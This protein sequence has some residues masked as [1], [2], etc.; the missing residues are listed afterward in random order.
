MR[1]IRMYFC[2]SDIG[3]KYVESVADYYRLNVFRV[4]HYLEDEIRNL[5]DRNH[6]RIKELVEEYYGKVGAVIVI[7]DDS[8]VMHVLVADNLEDAV[9][10]VDAVTHVG[11]GEEN[12]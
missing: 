7:E 3:L 10:L 12:I 11:V 5:L 6:K 8:P 2:N 9:F 1:F 4:P